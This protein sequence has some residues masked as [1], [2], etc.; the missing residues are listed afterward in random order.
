MKKRLRKKLMLQEFQQLG[1]RF[2]FNFIEP[3]N[4]PQEWQFLEDLMAYEDANNIS[5]GGGSASFYVYSKFRGT[6]V[7]PQQRQNFIEWLSRRTDIINVEVEPL[8]D[9]W[10]PRRAKGQVRQNPDDV[11]VFLL[12]TARHA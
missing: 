7:T 9:A 1:F 8:T 12:Q 6:S 5:A 3:T 2:R 10:Y 4:E 11:S